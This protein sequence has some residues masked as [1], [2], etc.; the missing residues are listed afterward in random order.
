MF[1][2]KSL[3]LLQ[4][5]LLSHKTPLYY[6]ALAHTQLFLA[7]LHFKNQD[8][9]RFEAQLKKAA[10]SLAQLPDDHSLA[11]QYRLLLSQDIPEKTPRTNSLSKAR[12][13][14]SQRSL[15]QIQS[16]QSTFAKTT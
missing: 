13:S 6:Q 2:N 10:V 14:S 11:Q 15:H 3:F 4:D 16:I 9:G 8:P 1:V 7:T 5:L 12:P